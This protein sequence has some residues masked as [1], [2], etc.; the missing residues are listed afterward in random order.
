MQFFED[1]QIV[2]KWITGTNIMHNIH[3]S[4]M[5]DEVRKFINEFEIMDI[6]HIYKEI[7]V[8]VHELDKDGV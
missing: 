6:K 4:P 5:L 1:S 8:L 2:I 3:L 7:N